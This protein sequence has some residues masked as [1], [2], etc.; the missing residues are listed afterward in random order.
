MSKMT[1]VAPGT[2]SWGT[3]PGFTTERLFPSGLEDD[4]ALEPYD[5]ATGGLK[6]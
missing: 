6:G 2:E 1:S 3:V 4:T 5:I